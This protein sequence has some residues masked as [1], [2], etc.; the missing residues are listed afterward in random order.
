MAPRTACRAAFA[1]RWAR[2]RKGSPSG[3]EHPQEVLA[4]DFPDV[5]VAVAA[6]LEG[7]GEERQRR[8]VVHGGWKHRDAVEV[9]PQRDVVHAHHPHRMVDVIDQPLDPRHRQ[10][11]QVRGAE[12]VHLEFRQARL[13]LPPR[14]NGIEL[15]PEAPALRHVARPETVVQE[16][17]EEVDADNPARPGHGAELLVAHVPRWAREF[18]LAWPPSSPMRAA[19][20]P[21]AAAARTSSAVMASSTAGF[22][23][24]SCLTAPINASARRKAVPGP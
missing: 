20:C 5:A 4:E 8:H 23:S 1:T 14:A 11:V 22:V 10:A 19:T 9:A 24:A 3:T 18:S 13:I 16:R 12:L 15:G 2:P 17:G 7:P 21:R 6:G